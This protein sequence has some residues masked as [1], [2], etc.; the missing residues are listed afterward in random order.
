MLVDVNFY[1]TSLPLF[2]YLFES[3]ASDPKTLTGAGTIR[4]KIYFMGRNKKESKQ[5]SKIK[6]S[7]P[8][9]NLSAET[10]R[11]IVVIVFGVLALVTL[12][13]VVNLA[14]ALS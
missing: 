6:F 1:L 11:G 14:G 12:L 7:P 2:P 4:I 10:K 13:A 5:E 9:L 8:E 3:L